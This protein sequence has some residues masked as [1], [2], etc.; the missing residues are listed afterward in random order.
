MTFAGFALR[1][2]LLVPAAAQAGD[3]PTVDRVEYVLECMKDHDGK[4]EYLYKCSCV[5]D[6]IAKRL[7]YEDYVVISAALRYQ[8]LAGE[9]GAEFRDPAS[10]KAMANKYKT[11]QAEANKACFV[12]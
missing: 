11:I 4:H 10:V 7:S 2:M 5:I 8:G 6:A 9:R 12:Q 3:F 1:L